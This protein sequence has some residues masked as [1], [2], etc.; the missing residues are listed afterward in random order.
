M[1]IKRMLYKSR[2]RAMEDAIESWQRDHAHAMGVRDVED[3]VRESLGIRDFLRQWSKDAWEGMRGNC[4]ADVQWV[5]STLLE[6]MNDGREIFEDAHR[7]IT[8]AEALGYTVDERA[9][10]DRASEELTEMTEHLQRH[11]PWMHEDVQARS[12]AD[13]QAGRVR[14]AR[15]VLDE[16]QRSDN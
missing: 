3:L 4:F 11:W 5:G 6:A 14:R 1:Q 16:L 15:D 2:V 9:N 7:C 8:D 13:I 12:L 10:F